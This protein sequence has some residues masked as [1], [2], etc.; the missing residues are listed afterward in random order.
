[1]TGQK[2]VESAVKQELAYGSWPSPISAEMVAKGALRLSQ[3]SF[4]LL[5]SGAVL[6]DAALRKGVV[7]EDGHGPELTSSVCQGLVF[8]LEGRPAEGG[9]QV[10]V[11]ENLFSGER[12][13]WN[14]APANIR[15]SVHEYGGGAYCLS[16]LGIVYSDYKDQGL[17]LLSWSEGGEARLICASPGRRYADLS[18][19]ESRSSV[20]AV[21]EE[22]AEERGQGYKEAGK[23][24]ERGEEQP[25][26]VGNATGGARLA[27]QAE[28]KPGEQHG[29][30]P[31]AQAGP[32]QEPVNSLV[33]VSL[34]D[35]S[36]RVLSSG[37]DFYGF[38]RLSADGRFLSAIAWRHP[39]MPWD[40][41]V[42][43]LIELDAA[44]LPVKETVV[45]GGAG[46]S[47]FQPFWG[48]DGGLYFFNDPQGFWRPYRIA[49]P[50][51]DNNVI[52]PLLGA[53]ELAE[54]EFG[55]PMW[56]FGQSV[57]A[58]TD[59]HTLFMAG[60]EKGLWGLYKLSLAGGKSGRQTDVVSVEKVTAPYTEISSL[61]PAGDSLVL[62]AGSSSSPNSV[63][64]YDVQDQAFKIM[65]AACDELPRDE[66]LS[67][68]RVLAFE[69]QRSGMSYA[70]YYAPKNQQFIGGEAELPPLLVKCHGGPTGGASSLLSLGIQYY[71]SR[72]FAVVDV[73]YGG[74]TG[75]GR[76]YR[77]RL[78][79]NWGVVDV[80]DVVSCVR[81]LVAA[82]FV[83]PKRIAISGGSAGGYTVLS[84]L[85]FTDEFSAGASHYGIG[86]LSSLA[87]DT[88]KFESRYEER[89]VGP[90]P[91]AK[92]VYVARSPLCH[93]EKLN[94]PVIFF[95]GL[96]D[97]VVPP[98]QAE[99]MVLALKKKGLPVSYL[100]YEGEQHG[101]RRA[102]NIIRT[103]ES[104]YSFFAKI[105]GIKPIELPSAWHELEIVN[106]GDKQ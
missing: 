92:D 34:K 9:R 77:E 4:S 19:D 51:L 93:V 23:A 101:F 81:H 43:L 72:G 5:N 2:A 59:A 3:P 25:A 68:P 94:C 53:D 75:F 97:K 54:V 20:L 6:G 55:L 32:K 37:Y 29:E 16:S 46:L 95:Q 61:A 74:S 103:I 22:H 41:N 30:K 42:L 36:C 67:S 80:E 79:G 91:A 28:G 63:V 78:L 100:A 15:S 65:K 71:T 104:E 76:E 85:T 102:A 82:G 86:D 26:A 17:Y 27:E 8:W 39:N 98:N 45:A 89:L 96:E 105:F 99:L 31:N 49:R 40:E 83:D 106:F 48:P 12:R 84:A 88:H 10:L 44:G 90:Y 69:N 21:M 24:V 7:K 66:C 56:V 50:G 64:L 58:F 14:L 87:E 11:S 1:M 60:C 52:E 38:P 33:S 18:V 47:V 35:G 70:F 13:D 62:L 73:N 57:A